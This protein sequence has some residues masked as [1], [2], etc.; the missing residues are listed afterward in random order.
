[1]IVVSNA[2]TLI[3]LAKISHFHLPQRL[4]IEITISEEVWDEVVVNGAGL[5]GFGKAVWT[6]SASSFGPTL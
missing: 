3:I 1:V 2:S 5:L 4:F 6:L